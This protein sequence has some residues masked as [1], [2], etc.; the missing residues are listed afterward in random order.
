MVRPPSVNDHKRERQSAVMSAGHANGAGIAVG[1]VAGGGSLPGEAAAAIVRHGGRV[2]VA[3]VKGAAETDITQF[4]HTPVH[5]SALGKTLNT[6]RRE[7]IRDVLLLGRF[8]RPSLSD[9]RPD[10]TFI[11]ALREVVSLL[12][13]GGDDALLRALIAIFETR[14]FRVVGIRDCAADL[15]VGEGPLGARAP[16]GGCLDDIELGMKVVAALGHFDIGQGVIVRDGKVIAIE[17]AEGTDRMLARIAERCAARGDT[18]ATGVLVKRPKPGQ[19]L[20]VDLPTIGPGTVAGAHAARLAGIAVMADHVI[21]AERDATARAADEA[22]LFVAGVDAARFTADPLPT[23]RGDAAAVCFAPCSRA[24]PSPRDVDDAKFGVGIL[25]EIADLAMPCAAVVW[26][27]R[28]LAIGSDETV[29]DVLDRVHRRRRRSGA[30]IIGPNAQ[31]STEVVK[32]A[33][34]LRLGVVAN[35]GAFLEPDP[36]KAYARDCVVIVRADQEA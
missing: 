31:C 33:N 35:M 23:A 36:Q 4:P 12:R 21:V 10:W 15:L 3:A 26:R 6:F 14:G 1:I 19:D 29:N 25:R 5:W 30:L 22:G 18:R 8:Q 9:A 27:G 24:A 17:A 20:R 7:N 11:A 32:R 2:H 13:Q 16:G 34:A 28:V